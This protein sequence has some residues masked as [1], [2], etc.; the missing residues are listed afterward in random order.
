MQHEGII[1]IASEHDLDISLLTDAFDGAETDAKH[2]FADNAVM[3]SIEQVVEPDGQHVE[4]LF[5]KEGLGRKFM[6]VV[7]GVMGVLSLFT[8]ASIPLGLLAAAAWYF[9]GFFLWDWGTIA[10]EQAKTIQQAKETDSPKKKAELKKRYE[11]LARASK[12]IKELKSKKPWKDPKVAAK[13]VKKD[14]ARVKQVLRAIEQ[15]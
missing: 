3:A 9:A 5:G 2:D 7:A 4:A 11:K 6:G 14:P 8:V 15:A 1:A 10:A 12:T 13:L